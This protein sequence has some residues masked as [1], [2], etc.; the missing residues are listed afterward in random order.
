M[1]IEPID[2]E[3]GKETGQKVTHVVAPGG[4]F[5]KACTFL[6]KK[7]TILLPRPGRRRRRCRDQEEESRQQNQVYLPRLRLQRLGQAGRQSVVRR[8]P[9]PDGSFMINA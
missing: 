1:A 6:A 2:A 3:S 4:R 8:L 9:T 5:E 7:P